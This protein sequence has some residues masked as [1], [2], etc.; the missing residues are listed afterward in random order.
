[1]MQR[2]LTKYGL[3]SHIACVVLFPLLFIAQSRAL[4]LVPLLWLSLIALELMVLLPSVRRGETLADARQHLWPALAWDPLLYLGL[5]LVGVLLTQWANSGCELI[6]LTDADVWQFSKPALAWAPFSVETSAALSYV[7]VFSAC[8]VVALTLRVAVSKESKRLL[9]QWLAGVS[10]CVAFYCVYQACQGVEPYAGKALVP[11]ATTMGTFYG[12]WLLLG[13][14]GFVDAL[15]RRQRGIEPLFLFG[16]VGNLLG[17]IYFASALALCCYGVLTLFLFVYGLIYLG[18]YVA[19]SVQLKLFLLSSTLVACVALLLIFVFPGNPVVSK[20]KAA[21]PLTAYWDALIAI[22]KIKAAAALGIWQEHPWTGVGADG[23][24]HFA[25]LTAVGKDWRA[26]KTDPASAYN[27]SLQFLCEFGV[28]G[29]GLLLS[30]IIT[31][32]VPL[33]YRMRIAFKEGTHDENAG[34]FFLLRVSPIVLTGV[35]AMLVCF[36]ES[37]IANP[38]RSY[39]LLLSWTCVMVVL[40]A[41]LPARSLAAAKG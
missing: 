26:V 27:D 22:K 13:M 31:M 14:G 40:P 19:K 32:L 2:L 6:Y 16:I 36:L 20:I 8:V 30:A 1:M 34:R 38:F 23:F 24:R 33:C 5:A 39:S 3:V 28:L 21:L 41:F 35:L 4:N 17:M 29:A 7:S 12:F 18:P 25:G 10:G 11:G 9:L 37:W 15:A